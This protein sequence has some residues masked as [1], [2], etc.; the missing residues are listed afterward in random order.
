MKEFGPEGF[1]FYTNYESRKGRELQANP[2][3]ALVFYWEP[4]KR[5]V[6]VEGK[7]EK[8]RQSLNQGNRN[9]STYQWTL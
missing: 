6:R 4:F 2:N 5:S 3:A 1:V 8:V 9:Y 7:V